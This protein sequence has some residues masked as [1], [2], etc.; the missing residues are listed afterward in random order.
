VQAFLHPSPDNTQELEQLRAE[1][2][3]RLGT[4][5]TFGFGPRYLHSTGQLHKGGPNTVLVL[6]I[7]DQPT[8]NLAVPETTYTFDALIQA[9]SLGDHAALKQRRRR[10]LR[11]NLGRDA[12]SGLR[13]L[14]GALQA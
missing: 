11:V 8:N 1:L 14:I 4:A 7:V 12:L 2:Q 10:M 5:T 9:Q 6:Q 13:A 3:E